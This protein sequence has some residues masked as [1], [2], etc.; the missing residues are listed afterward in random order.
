[1]YDSMKVLGPG[2]GAFKTKVKFQFLAM[3]RIYHP[4]KQKTE[5]TASKEE[6]ATTLFKLL[7]NTHYYLS[8]V[9]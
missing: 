5:H 1:M 6:Y 8:G 4:D 3:S 7:N 2:F 9:L